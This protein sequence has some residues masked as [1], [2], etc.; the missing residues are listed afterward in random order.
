MKKLILVSMVLAMIGIANAEPTLTGVLDSIY[1]A[2]HYTPVTPDVIWLDLNGGVLGVAKYADDSH[3]LGYS[4]DENG[5][6][7]ITWFTATPFVVGS[8]ESFNVTGDGLFIWALKDVS[9]TN[10]WYSNPLLNS[11]G[12]DHML[13]YEITTMTDTYAICWEDRAYPGGDADYQ[14]LVVQVTNAVPIPAP[15][16][17]L[18][19]SIGVALVG[20]LRRQRAL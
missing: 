4:T 20:W 10:T 7:G 6:S 17:I 2:G 3:W 13:T 14:D 18:L 11:D 16:A 1:G 15:G 19:G 9:T 12:E 8:S 5:G